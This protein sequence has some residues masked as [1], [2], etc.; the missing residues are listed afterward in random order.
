MKLSQ[1]RVCR[2]CGCFEHSAC[3]SGLTDDTRDVCSWL[4]PGRCSFCAMEAKPAPQLLHRAR[5]LLA[6]WWCEAS[7]LRD[8]LKTPAGEK[9]S[10]ALVVLAVKA[11]HRS[12]VIRALQEYVPSNVA[13]SLAG[14]F[15]FSPGTQG[16]S[17]VLAG[18]GLLVVE[19]ILQ[20]QRALQGRK[21]SPSRR[22]A[23]S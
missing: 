3:V 19:S 6:W 10:L 23:R 1:V 9:A 20:A 15:A 5:R 13:E 21:R 2:F 14:R 4:E 7:T 8:R 18:P 11:G 12:L 22:E 16:G 17:W